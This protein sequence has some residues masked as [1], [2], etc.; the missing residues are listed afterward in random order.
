[1]NWKV[2]ALEK[3]F[4]EKNLRDVAVTESVQSCFELSMHFPVFF[5]AIY[6]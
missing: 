5:P 6:F 2:L 4:K 1:M 3:G